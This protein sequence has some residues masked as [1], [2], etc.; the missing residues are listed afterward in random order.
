MGQVLAIWIAPEGKA[1]MLPRAEVKAIEGQ[2]LDGDRYAS[3]LGSYSDK[4]GTGRHV[5]LI[6]QEALDAIRRENG[7]DLRPGAHRRNVVVTGVAL[8]HLVDREFRVGD[9]VLRG[10]RLCEPCNDLAQ[11]IGEPI[12]T[13]LLHRAG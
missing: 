9:V 8:N 12:T 7:I 2:G 10:M 13:P 3:G 5:T 1:A 4:P 6:E 11:A